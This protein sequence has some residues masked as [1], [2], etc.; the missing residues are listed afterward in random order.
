MKF[1]NKINFKEFNSTI[2]VDINTSNTI[3]INNLLIK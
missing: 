1:L 3:I 2:Y